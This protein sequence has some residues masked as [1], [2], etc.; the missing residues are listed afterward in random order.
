MDLFP[1]S[2][3][4]KRY[5]TYAYFLKQRYGGRVAKITLDGGFTCPNIDGTLDTG[6]CTFCSARGSGEFAGNRTSSIGQQ[7]AQVVEKLSEKWN[8]P[9]YIA[10][11]QPFTNT[12]G[13]VAQLRA[14]YEEALSLPGVVGLAIATRPDC[15]PPAV[16]DL[17]EE[18]AQKTD[19]TVELGLQTIWEQTSRRIHRHHSYKDFLQ[20]F[21]ALTKRGIPVCVH[22]INGL[23]GETSVQMVESARQVGS[24]RPQFVKLHLLHVLKNTQLAEEYAAGAFPLLTREA[25]VS[26]VCDQLEVLPPETVIQRLTGDGKAS[27][28]IGPIW[29]IAKMQVMNEIDK[30]LVRRNSW[31]GKKYK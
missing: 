12:Y 16:L 25:Y 6:G 18:L 27:D 9:R 23:P 10:Y 21:Q 17:L 19:L 30:E 4:N 5:H 3:T 31:Q 8:T 22:L 11:F 26:I 13:P 24:L 2:D 14:V 7:F 20:G 28:L 1:Y 15:L 29:S